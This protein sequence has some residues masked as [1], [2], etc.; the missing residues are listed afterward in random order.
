[1]TTYK[2]APSLY[3]H[4]AQATA[5]EVVEWPESVEVHEQPLTDEQAAAFRRAMEERNARPEA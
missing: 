1:M 3:E 2:P 4:R 5:W